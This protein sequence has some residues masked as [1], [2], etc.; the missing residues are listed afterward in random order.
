MCLGTYSC[1]PYIIYFTALR[2]ECKSRIIK[3]LFLFS[4]SS[5]YHY[6]CYFI[7]IIITASLLSPPLLHFLNIFNPYCTAAPGAERTSFFPGGTFTWDYQRLP[8][9]EG[10]REGEGELEREGERLSLS[11][12]FPLPLMYSRHF[13]AFL[14]QFMLNILRCLFLFG[15]VTM[16]KKKKNSSMH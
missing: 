15:V 12:I 8:G 5:S 1:T 13:N 11:E 4:S 9:R 2:T 7:I 16:I 3:L 6:Y 14:K 10:E